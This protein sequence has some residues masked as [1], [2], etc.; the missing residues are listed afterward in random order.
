[1]RTLAAGVGLGADRLDLPLG[2]LSG[3][4]RRRARA[5]AHP[6]RR[7]RAAAARRAHEPP[8]RRRPQLAP[9]VPA[10]VPRRARRGE[11]RPRPARRR[12]HPRPAH[13]P[14]GRGARRARSSSTRA[15][16][17]STSTARDQRRGSAAPKL[18]PARTR[19]IAR[20]STLANSMR[21]Q[22][23]EARPAGQEPRHPRRA[24]SK[25]ERVDAPKRRRALTLRFPDATAERAHRAHRHR[26]VED[27][28]HARRV[29]R[30]QLRRR[31]RRA[32][33]RDGP[34]RRRARPR[35]S[36]CSPTG[37]SPTSAR[38]SSGTN[39]SLGYYAQEHEG[40]RGRAHACSSTCARRPTSATATC[41]AL[42]G[43]FGLT[44][45]EGVPG[46]GHAVG[47]RED[48]ARA[49]AARRRSP[50]PAA[51]R[52]A[53]QQPRPAVAHRDRRRRWPRGRAR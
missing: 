6:L 33:A 21:G 30:R 42:L 4:E 1:M 25:R 48:Q 17:R 15:R 23:A 46:R 51:A 10:R 50:Q 27:V 7:Q 41:A 11:P 19:E 24:A 36:R 47:R 12:D 37:S 53:D 20:L 39:V 52:R 43:M 38:S 26:A 40:I 2:A 29:L 8:R 9:Q 5:R 16:T 34:Q 14:R 35:C 31:P 32:A 18:A 49:R 3:G 44:R 22:T 45:P 13:R 28:R